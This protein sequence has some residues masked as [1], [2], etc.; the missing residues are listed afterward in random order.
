[1]PDG[2]HAVRAEQQ[3]RDGKGGDRGDQGGRQDAAGTAGVKLAQGWGL[4]GIGALPQQNAGD[5]VARDYEEDV[6]PD[7]PAL[8]AGELDVVGDH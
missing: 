5:Q 3:R 2:L 4:A 8:E 1:M 7:E 6:D